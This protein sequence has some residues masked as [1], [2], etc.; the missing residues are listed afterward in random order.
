M[1]LTSA[2]RQALAWL[3][4]ASVFALLV[5]L[6]APVLTPFIIAAV[7]A[8]VLYPLMRWLR[9]H[10]L[11]GPAASGL[12]VVLVVLVV[13][14]VTL[15]LVP[16]VSKQ[17]PLL[18]EQVP[19]L[20]ARAGDALAPLASR[21]GVD[22]VDGAAQL[23]DWVGAHWGSWSGKLLQSA[24]IGGSVV[25]SVVGN[26]ILIPLVLFYLL[27]E[28]ETIGAQLF[29][30]VPPRHRT[31]LAG[32][33]QECDEVLGQYVRGQLL[34]MLAL[35]V[36]YTVGLALAGFTLALPIGVFT[37]LAVFIPYLGFSMGLVLAL[38]A[39]LLQ[40]GSWWGVGAVA[41]IYGA[42]QVIESWFLTPYW[43]GERIGLHPLAVIFALLAFGQLFGFVG[44]LLALPLAALLLVALRRVLQRYRASA[45]FNP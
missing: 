32:F 31:A 12:V 16:I 17:L 3:L 42:G 29:A 44:V 43:V 40:F 22:L 14:A 2:Q 11:P 34:V 13:L 15:L 39:A 25:L 1:P 9:R 37:G 8:Y 7:L 5:W 4:I 21:L 33:L 41:I 10:R 18:R 36:F 27:L 19:V 6:L 38:V 30:A 45:L 23:R 20:L 35:A 26:A 24:L 28:W